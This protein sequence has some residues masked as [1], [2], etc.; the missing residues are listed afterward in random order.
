MTSLAG[1]R[2]KHPERDGHLL[3]TRSPVDEKASE[4]K[5]SPVPARVLNSDECA[6]PSVRSQVFRVFNSSV[7]MITHPPALTAEQLAKMPESVDFLPRQDKETRG[8]CTAE[9]DP[10]LWAR[11]LVD[12]IDVVNAGLFYFAEVLHLSPIRHSAVLRVG[13]K[14]IDGVFFAMKMQHRNTNVPTLKREWDALQI[15]SETGIVP[16]PYFRGHYGDMNFIVVRLYAGDVERY[17]KKTTSSLS[18]ITASC[19][20]LWLVGAL[21]KLRQKGVVHG[22]INT[23]NI[24][25][26]MEGGSAHLA[27]CGLEFVTRPSS[28]SVGSRLLIYFGGCPRFE[29]CASTHN[30][31]DNAIPRSEILQKT[32]SSSSTSPTSAESPVAV[33][34]ISHADD[35]ENACYTIIFMAAG[36][37]PWDAVP[38]VA[39]ERL[40]KMVA[41]K[42]TIDWNESLWARLRLL[43]ELMQIA[44]YCQAPPRD[45]KQADLD[46]IEDLLQ[47]MIHDNSL[48]PVGSEQLFEWNVADHKWPTMRE[49]VSRS[50]LPARDGDQAAQATTYAFAC[51]LVTEHINQRA[52]LS[53]SF[54]LLKETQD[55]AYRVFDEDASVDLPRGPGLQRKSHFSLDRVV[56]HLAE[57]SR[58]SA[59]HKRNFDDMIATNA[60]SQ[61][62]FLTEQRIVIDNTIKDDLAE[63]QEPRVT[64]RRLF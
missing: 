48:L 30:F 31:L 14:G 1:L 55:Q 3:V 6:A 4:P 9:R 58:R 22:D 47:D 18:A 29:S 49:V 62:L 42:E 24:L 41:L 37:L 52:D 50:R 23:A 39:K 61:E 60:G 57:E 26:T 2:L 56:A 11:R 15:L 8:H 17:M 53:T 45:R 27:L 33:P 25:Y 16:T 19:T 10:A 13:I 63:A 54:R 5:P 59:Q 43:P 12:D 7:K 44:S 38:G 64:R 40:H 51:Q 35:M 28:L 32:S 46:Y 21:R 36:T 20:A 34:C